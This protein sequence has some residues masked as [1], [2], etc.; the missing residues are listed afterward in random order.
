LPAAHG[1]HARS[2][3]LLGF[4]IWYCPPGHGPDQGVH[5]ATFCAALNVPA[6]HSMQRRCALSEPGF[7]ASM[8]VPLGQ[9][10]KGAQVFR[11]GSAVKV[12]SVQAWHL[13]FV[14]VLPSSRMRVPAAQVAHG[15]HVSALTVVLKVPAAHGLQVRLV[16]ALPFDMM[17]VPAAQSVRATH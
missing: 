17:N 9:F 13:R 10:T 14:I 16:V 11:F 12:P 3:V 5:A 15:L 1:E 8:C 7:A 6:S 2:F 4:V